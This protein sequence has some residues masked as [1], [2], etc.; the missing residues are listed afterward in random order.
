MA[1]DGQ[2]PK[3]SLITARKSDIQRNNTG[4]QS[5]LCMEI[6][7]AG[8]D[9]YYFSIRTSPI[10]PLPWYCCEGVYKYRSNS[11]QSIA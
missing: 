2:M 11:S 1:I 7:R 10:I 3:L 8:S 9:G 6:Q 4:T 5:S